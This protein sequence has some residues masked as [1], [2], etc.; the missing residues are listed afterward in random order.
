MVLDWMRKRARWLLALLGLPLV[1]WLSLVFLLPKG[2]TIGCFTTGLARISGQ[3]VHLKSV[4]G[5]LMGGL[6]LA[7]L[8]VSKPGASTSP[9]ADPWFEAQSVR[10]DVG[11]W[12]V[13][14]GRLEPT[15][16]RVEKGRLRILRGADGVLELADLL[17]PRD[18]DGPNRIHGERVPLTIEIIDCE[19]LIVDE[20]TRTRMNIKGLNGLA[21]REGRR[22]TVSELS[23]T[24]NGG[25]FRMAAQLDRTSSMPLAELR[26]RADDVVMDDGMSILRYVAP[27]LSGARLHLKGR[28]STDLYLA[29]RPVNRETFLRSLEG[30]GSLALSPIDL[31]GADLVD[32]LARI[33]EMPGQ[34]RTA[35]I[36][37][38]FI[39]KDQRITTEHSTLNIGR[40]PLILAGST[41]LDGAIDYH[42]RIDGLDG[43]MSNQARRLLS[44]LKLELSD[45][46]SLNLKGTVDDMVVQAGGISIDNVTKK[47]GI[48]VSDQ[49]KLKR[50]GRQ[51]RDRLLR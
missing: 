3:T 7:H 38:D 51:L 48:S 15:H 10:V 41:R 12:Q 50:I 13:L 32:E 2:W 19:L 17:R 25:P 44:D 9:A 49:E 5:C 27:V 23:G 35:S 26:L 37:S 45:V 39:V 1:G 34:G 40:I 33:G 24:L 14:Q 20:P 21:T 31:D 30:H 28:L 36:R 16:I 18:D 47:A 42:I 4:S 6:E 22:I 29:A 46:T 43:R 11:L 8:E